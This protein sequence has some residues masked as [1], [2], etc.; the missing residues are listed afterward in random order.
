MTIQNTKTS[1]STH[2]YY[3]HTIIKIL[4]TWLYADSPEICS[5]NQ[6]TLTLQKSRTQKTRGSFISKKHTNDSL[7]Y[8]IRSKAVLTL[9]IADQ[10]PWPSWRLRNLRPCQ[11]EIIADAGHT[12]SRISHQ[13]YK[14]MLPF[15]S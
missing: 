15:N 5:R 2:Y 11:T 10:W 13:I 3:D 14:A 9:D 8:K 1:L 7:R 6:G 4:Q 12:S